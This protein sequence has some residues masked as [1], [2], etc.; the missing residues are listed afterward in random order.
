MCFEITLLIISNCKGNVYMK[1][2]LSVIILTSILFSML[3]MPSFALSEARYEIPFEVD[4]KSYVLYSID[5]K[6]IIFEKNMHETY[7][8]ASL[9]KLMT[10]YLT[11]KNIE[12]LENT[13]ITAPSYVYDELYL[14]GG[15]TADIRQNEAVSASNLIHAMLLPSGNEAA[16]IIADY[17]GGG[18][19][20]NFFMMM[21][22]EG[23]KLGM[24]NTNF[25]NA[26]GLFSDNH[27]S[28]AYDMLQLAIACY[29]TPG[30]MEIATKTGHYMP[31]TSHPNHQNEYYIQST[32]YMQN[33]TSSFYQPYIRGMKTGSLPEIGHNFV[34]VC[35]A[36]G[37]NYILV[38]IGADDYNE[39]AAFYTTPIIMDH[40]YE[41]YTLKSANNLE[42]PVTEVDLKYASESDV[43]LLYP[44][45]HVMS[46][47]PNTADETSFSKEY[48][49]PQSVSA[50]INAGDV[51]GTV[52]YY[53]A[54]QKV[55]T[56]DLVSKETYERDTL[57]YII[58]KI[59]EI[60]SSLYFR[61]VVVVTVLLFIGY[62]VFA[63]MHIN[64]QKK[65]NK[66][67]RSKGNRK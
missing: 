3:I 51:I 7:T 2:F 17:L 4:A 66:I 40:F 63:Y 32:I 29:E 57:I 47:L 49:I 58:E 61:V 15:S 56:S 10:S 30:F 11:F 23:E 22:T 26:H 5:T 48:N 67:I 6:E 21:N 52:D 60:F 31:A 59:G 50:P 55:G 28:T 39:R 16:N 35:E 42:L 13:M 25:S 41:N 1:K 64:K 18:N 37:E 20:G 27:Y 33:P 19:M 24:Q 43:L 9:T 36:N 54:G 8:P 38:I 46:V 62:L 34:T 12:D 45:S 53:L 65:M 14:M 44:S